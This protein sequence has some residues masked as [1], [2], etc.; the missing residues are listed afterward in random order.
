MT[1][2]EEAVA[3]P[4]G[5]RWVLA[6]GDLGEEPVASASQARLWTAVPS[7]KAL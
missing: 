1:E 5:R 4:G 2:T 7:T 3:M 6:P